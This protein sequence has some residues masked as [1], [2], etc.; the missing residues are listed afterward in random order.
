MNGSAQE[1]IIKIGLEYPEGMAV[2]WVAH[3]IY[4]ADSGTSK[5]EMSRLD[6]LHRKVLVWKDIHSPRA[7]ALDPPSG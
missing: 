4:W 3:N 1:E 2:D 5:I 6:G 7:I